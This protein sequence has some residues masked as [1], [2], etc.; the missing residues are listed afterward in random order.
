VLMLVFGPFASCLWFAL[1]VRA[2]QRNDFFHKFGYSEPK[3]YGT[4]AWYAFMGF[5]ISLLAGGYV[6]FT[7]DD[8][9]PTLY[10]L[11]AVVACFSPSLLYLTYR[12]FRTKEAPEPLIYTS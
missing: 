3:Q 10:F 1:V 11:K 2:Y 6:A 9:N 7:Q 12:I 8:A 5:L 4:A